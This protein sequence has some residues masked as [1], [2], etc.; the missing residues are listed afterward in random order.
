MIRPAPPRRGSARL[1]RRPY[2]GRVR[3]IR[4]L[5]PRW[6]QLAREATSFA[7][8]GGVNFVI[9]WAVFNAFLSIGPLKAKVIST[10]V[11]ATTS[12]FMNRHWTY[13]DRPRAALHRE[14]LLF[15][16]FNAVGFAINE[17]ALAVARYGLGHTSVLALNIAN[18]IGVALA[19]VFRF[20]TYRHL[21]FRDAA[22]AK[23]AVPVS[24]QVEPAPA[25]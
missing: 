17:F 7:L 6:Q 16:L 8:I 4:L 18:V 23:P 9:D 19:M 2:G 24:E 10:V 3:L 25:Q 14:Y 22:P 20:V 1:D 13:R 21:V 12:F 11:S 15:F 5:P